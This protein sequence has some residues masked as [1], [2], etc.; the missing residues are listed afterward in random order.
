V[1][2]PSWLHISS[3]AIA[4]RKPETHKEGSPLGSP[5]D[6][7]GVQSLEEGRSQMAMYCGIDLHSNNGYVAIQDESH[8]DIANRRLR[9]DLQLVLGFLEPYREE[10]EAIAVESTFNWY[11]LVDGLMDAGYDVRLVN[12]TKASNYEGLKYTDDKNDARW[13]AHLM[14]LGILPEGY[15]MPRHERGVRDLLRRRLFLVQKRTSCLLALKTVV[16]RNTGKQVS[17]DDIQKW[18]LQDL[19]GY[20][21]D[22]FVVESLA[23]MLRVSKVLTTEI[24]GI[25]RTVRQVAKLRNEF[26]LLQTAPG[27][28]EVLALTIM[29]ETGDIRRFSKVGNMARTAGASRANGRAT[30]QEKV[31][32]TARTATSACRG[33]TQ[34]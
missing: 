7:L 12:T 17:A 5:G 15:I 33:R 4:G 10:L 27:V 18:S 28:G 24:K 22:R 23:T 9:N 25:E 3:P 31:K 19:G 13:I 14:V 20:F 32:G 2:Q 26:R 34:K 1:V 11:W 6:K 21:E 29:C 8:K 16:A 30:T